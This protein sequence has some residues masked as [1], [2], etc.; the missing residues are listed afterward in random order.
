MESKSVQGSGLILINS[1]FLLLDSGFLVLNFR[2]LL[3][4]GFRILCIASSVF[5][6]RGFRNPILLD[7]ELL[8]ATIF[9]IPHFRISLQRAKVS[10]AIV[11]LSFFW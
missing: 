9:Q 4:G 8:L 1:G 6:I 5:Q 10:D 11:M 7:A 2:I 3:V